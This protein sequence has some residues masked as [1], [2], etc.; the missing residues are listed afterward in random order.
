MIGR[1]MNRRVIAAGSVS[2]IGAIM[3]TGTSIVLVGAGDLPPPITRVEE[4]WEA[5]L[6]DPGEFIDAPQFHT[7]MSPVGTVDGVH[8]QVCWNYRELPSYVSGGMEYMGWDADD[9][10]VYKPIREDKFSYTAE[11][12]RWTQS[13]R[14]QCGHAIF[15]VK[16]GYSQTWGEFGGPQ[17]AIQFPAA[18][19]DLRK[20]EVSHSIENSWISYGANRVDVLR[21]VAVRYFDAN[22]TLVYEDRI[23]K[24][25]Y[26]LDE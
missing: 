16:D 25:V 18:F 13:M 17:T 15:Y 6:N 21:I 8:F 11:T 5:V 3:L 23:P 7:V 9:L 10:L 4:V 14:V 2:V 24:V 19:P 22:G 1:N 20:Y 26:E 12:V